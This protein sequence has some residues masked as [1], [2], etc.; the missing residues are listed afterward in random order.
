MRDSLK[1]SFKNIEEVSEEDLYKT[2]QDWQTWLST[3]RN[4]SKNTSLAYAYDFKYFLNFLSLHFEK[5]KI[6][7]DLL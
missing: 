5:N 2:Y 7:L 1:S 3:F 4:L 6:N